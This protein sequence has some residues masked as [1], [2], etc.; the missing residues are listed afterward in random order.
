MSEMAKVQYAPLERPS[1]ESGKPVPAVVLDDTGALPQCNGCIGPASAGAREVAIARSK[2]S[3]PAGARGRSRYH[4]PRD[5][6]GAQSGF[7]S[8][9]YPVCGN[10]SPILLHEADLYDHLVGAG[11]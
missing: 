7:G 4:R 2:C 9:S 1:F 11:G 3:M 10:S 6:C 8:S 5:Q